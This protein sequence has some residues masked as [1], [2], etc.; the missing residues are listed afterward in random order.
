MSDS[1]SFINE[2]TEEVRRDRLYQTFRRYGWIAITAIILLVGGAAWN[3]WRKA[4]ERSAA[5]GLGDSILAALNAEDRA[6]RAAALAAI[7][8][9]EGSAEA[10]VSLL[11]A[12][13]QSTV[14]PADAAARLFALADDPAVPQVYRQ[15]AVLKAVTIPDAGLSI[16]DRRTRLDGLTPVGG[17]VR[18]LAEEQLALLDIEEGGRDAAL[19][20]LQEIYQSAEATVSLRRRA[21][22]LIVALDGEIEETLVTP[23]TNGADNSN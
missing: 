3:E 6:D 8:A 14:A 19:I 13:E 9:P 11:A 17:L 1:D 22:Q 20:R 12:G 23:E 7:D 10:I 21:E 2:V 18:L 4:Q 15:I 16:E 5:E